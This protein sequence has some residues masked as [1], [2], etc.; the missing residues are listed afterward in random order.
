MGHDTRERVFLNWPLPRSLAARREYYNYRLASG[1]CHYHSGGQETERGSATS[2]C[3]Q[4]IRVGRLKTS[5]VLNPPSIDWL[6]VANLL[7]PRNN[8]KLYR[9]SSCPYTERSVSQ[10]VTQPNSGE[11]SKNP[12]SFVTCCGRISMNG[13]TRLQRNR[14]G[15]SH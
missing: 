9:A 8:L 13:L 11:Q 14:R 12:K 1:N 4:Q 7:S 15:D 10:S 6:A 2:T 5:S 3:R